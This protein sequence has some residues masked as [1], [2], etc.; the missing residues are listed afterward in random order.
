MSTRMMPIRQYTPIGRMEASLVGA[1]MLLYI[2]GGAK[3]KD[4]SRIS[5]WA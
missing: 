5:H 4:E 2:A 3:A 1:R